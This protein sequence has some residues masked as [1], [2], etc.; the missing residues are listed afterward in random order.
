MKPSYLFVNQYGY[1]QGIAQRVEAEGFDCYSWYSKEADKWFGRAGKN[2]INIVDDYHE[3]MDDFWDKKDDLVIIVDSNETGSEWD[4]ARKSGYHV[5]GSS[6]LTQRAE[7]CREDGNQLAEHLGLNIPPHVVFDDFAKAKQHLLKLKA[8]GYED[9]LVFKGDGIDMAGGGFTYLSHSIDELIE[10]IDW[11]YKGQTDSEEG[12]KVDK[13][14]FADIIKG[15]EM[16][17]EILFNGKEPLRAMAMDF[18]Q[19]RIHGLGEAQGCYGQIEYFLDPE[20]EPYYQKYFKKLLSEIKGD[21][22]VPWGINNIVQEGTNE[23]FFLEFTPRT[24]WDSTIGELMILQDA[25]HSIADFLHRWAY[26]EPFPKNYFPYR[27]YSC[28]VEIFS[29]TPGHKKKDI[30]YKPIF[31]DKKFEKN[32]WWYGIN[33]R[34]DGGYQVTGNPIGCVS[35]CGDTPDEARLKVYEILDPKNGH[36]KTPDIF[37]NENIGEGVTEEIKKLQDAGILSKE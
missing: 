23:P 8:K 16:D 33:Q 30:R 4:I 5:I 36:I 22:A 25:G 20:K 35:A 28:S 27:R 1:F 11:V 26:Q 9:N 13:F 14:L 15:L 21:V 12:Y 2:M 31:W 29:G 3:V 19:K 18:E 10:F 7:H 24:G 17:C 37:Y 6:R 32:I 34:D